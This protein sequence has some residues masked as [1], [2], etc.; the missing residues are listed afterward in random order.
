MTLTTGAPPPP[1]S[2]VEAEPHVSN[3]TERTPSSTEAEAATPTTAKPKQPQ[4]A[5]SDPYPTL[6]KAEGR[7]NV[8]SERHTNWRG[9]GESAVSP[10]DRETPLS[11]S[12]EGDQGFL[13][14]LATDA[15][16]LPDTPENAPIKQ[17]ANDFL[18]AVETR[19]GAGLR[20]DPLWRNWSEGGVRFDVPSSALTDDV[21][22][23]IN[24]S[25]P[26]TYIG[27]SNL[28]AGALDTARAAG[29]TVYDLANRGDALKARNLLNSISKDNLERLAE[30][31]ARVDAAA[32]YTATY[33]EIPRGAIIPEP[34]RLMSP[35]GTPAS[36]TQQ[37]ADWLAWRYIT[38]SEDDATRI[39][40]I[41]GGNQ[42]LF[43]TSTGRPVATRYATPA[44]TDEALIRLREARDKYQFIVNP[45]PTQAA[46][47]SDPG[48]LKRIVDSVLSP[49]VHFAHP[50]VMMMPGSGLRAKSKQFADWFRRLDELNRRVADGTEMAVGD[51]YLRILYTDHR[52]DY[53]TAEFGSRVIPYSPD[54]PYS[55]LAA[56]MPGTMTVQE[57][58]EFVSWREGADK[59]RLAAMTPSARARAIPYNAAAERRNIA[60]LAAGLAPTTRPTSA[61]GR[62]A[63]KALRAYDKGM[64]FFRNAK[65]AGPVTGFG[66]MMNDIIGNSFAKMISGNASWRDISNLMPW[67]IG[68]WIDDFRALGR[69]EIA[70]SATRSSQY[71]K[72]TGAVLPTDLMP[73]FRGM[74]DIHGGLPPINAAVANKPWLVRALANLGSVP[75]FM[76]ARRVHEVIDRLSIFEGKFRAELDASLSH[77]IRGADTAHGGAFFEAIER[78]H[79]GDGAKIIEDIRAE[80]RTRA[81]KQWSGGISPEDVL[82]ATG[83]H[84]LTRAWQGEINRAVERGKAESHRVFFSG[85]STKA[86]EVAR[87]AFT[88]HY[89]Q[90]RAS[91]FHLRTATRNPILLNTYWKLWQDINDRSAGLPR[92]LQSMVKVFTSGQGISAAINGFGYLLPMTALDMTDQD[93]NQF[94]QLFHLVAP[95]I[96]GI[97]AAGGADY[98]PNVDPFRGTEKLIVALINQAKVDGVPLDE[99]PIIG[100]HIDTDTLTNNHITEDIIN[101]IT[102]EV[103][104]RARGLLDKLGIPIGEFKPFDRDAYDYDLQVSAVQQVMEGMYGPRETWA[105]QPNGEQILSDY[106]TAVVAVANGSDGNPI[107]Q[108]AQAI[109]AEQQLISA[110]GNALLPGTAAWSDFRFGVQTDQAAAIAS[111]ENGTPLTPAQQGA[112]DNRQDATGADTLWNTVSDAYHR[113][114]TPEQQDL[115]Y[116]A[117]T[118][119]ANDS[120][121]SLQWIPA[122]TPDGQKVW[123]AGYE[124]ARMTDAE[125]VA[126]VEQWLTT[127]PNGIQQYQSYD[128][129]RQQFLADH[130]E[131]QDFK[132]YQG[133]VYDDPRGFRT[134]LAK[135]DPNFQRAME[136]EQDRL[137]GQGYKGE[138]LQQQLDDW[139][140]GESAYRAAIGQKVHQ[141]DPDPLAVYDPTADVTQNPGW[142]QPKESKPP[143]STTSFGDSG[144]FRKDFAEEPADDPSQRE[145]QLYKL[146]EQ[147]PQN[148]DVIAQ[149]TAI[150]K[151]ADLSD[152]NQAVSEW[153]QV[154]Q[155]NEQLYGDAWNSDTG[156]WESWAGTEK[157]RANAGLPS[158]VPYPPKPEILQTYWWWVQQYGNSD[159]QDYIDWWYENRDRPEFFQATP[160]QGAH[161]TGDGRPNTPP[162][163]AR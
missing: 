141:K 17:Q 127:W 11:A 71:L 97:L 28:D 78:A 18:E 83:D 43:D 49:Q 56:G 2:T 139:A 59:A 53:E 22:A 66:G 1:S 4:T 121:L 115:Y 138:K 65:L 13:D 159:I 126:W 42:K 63:W 88:F 99:I 120:D 111:L 102:S 20:D 72:D 95:M 47:W 105:Q 16:R 45:T 19:I 23:A 143:K 55:G 12:T 8:A 162:G 81:G 108:Q 153:Q 74:E 158:W 58:L 133:A 87:R 30:Y 155:S 124:L 160:E 52:I 104:D 48:I 92:G 82:K 34:V 68:R 54:V 107:A 31:G 148:K 130:P 144:L 26:N 86:D 142:P 14:D 51:D 116:T 44:L 100:S 125:R 110:G 80:A 10:A 93:G 140:K 27:S 35:A 69:D 60:H 119:L 129:S 94:A 106:N 96:Q 79:P 50:A 39:G 91:I 3:P 156:E 136:A 57:A 145:A 24:A 37:S 70:F 90:T 157:K 122:Y 132:T 152:F 101:A 40:Q 32:L 137:E 98:S 151:P 75:A 128:Q 131:Y 114:G 150:E 134:Q 15:S 76:D 77:G 154:N 85:A 113:L 161:W 33:G 38:G 67:R 29:L 135:T 9:T 123:V 109:V 7:S 64:S 84:D 41:L 118:I 149:I 163:Y 89:W 62:G 61:A 117:Q 21:V 147:Y 146:L 25:S 73:G 46:A 6:T 36:H 103:N 5:A 112:L